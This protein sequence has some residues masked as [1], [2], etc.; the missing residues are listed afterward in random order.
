MSVGLV[1]KVVGPKDLQKIEYVK[2]KNFLQD[3]WTCHVSQVRSKS[4]L[5]FSEYMSVRL[6]MIFCLFVKITSATYKSNIM[7]TKPSKFVRTLNK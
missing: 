4:F 5:I 7:S 6:I 3:Y 1:I 2:Y